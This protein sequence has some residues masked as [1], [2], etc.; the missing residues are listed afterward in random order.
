MKNEP[1][2]RASIICDIPSTFHTAPQRSNLDRRACSRNS[3]FCFLLKIDFLLQDKKRPKKHIAEKNSTTDVSRSQTIEWCYTGFIVLETLQHNYDE[4]NIIAL[5]RN[6]SYCS[7]LL[8]KTRLAL[9]PAA[10]HM[11]P[12]FCLN[13]AFSRFHRL[14]L[15]YSRYR[16]GWLTL[17]LLI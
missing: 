16:S 9:Q 1:M 3:P 15:L 6:G 10:E 13:K 8:P 4:H 14:L 5:V 2:A 17:V 12:P 7:L 11:I